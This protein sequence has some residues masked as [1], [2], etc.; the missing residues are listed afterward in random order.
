VGNQLHHCCKSLLLETDAA[1]D[2]KTEEIADFFGNAVRLLQD[3]SLGLL[4]RCEVEFVNSAEKLLQNVDEL[5]LGPLLLNFLEAAPQILAAHDIVI[6]A[7]ILNQ[8]SFEALS[9]SWLN[10]P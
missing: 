4:W 10:F 6:V 9:L 3:F 1:R 5:A 7:K 8:L 2:H